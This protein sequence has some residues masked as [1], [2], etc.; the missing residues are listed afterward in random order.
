MA[1]ERELKEVQSFYELH[2]HPN[3]F[4]S[5]TFKKKCVYSNGSILD[6]GLVHYSLDDKQAESVLA[7]KVD[8]TLTL[9]EN[10]INAIELTVK[11]M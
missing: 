10:I 3:R 8:E 5:I 6:A 11:E 4:A 9:G 1:I 2:F 7:C